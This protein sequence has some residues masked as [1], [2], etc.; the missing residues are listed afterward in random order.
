MAK[1]RRLPEPIALNDGRVLETLAD[2]RDLMI[3]LP[4][5]RYDRPHWEH[6][7]ELLTAAE[8]GNLARAVQFSDR[9]KDAL[10]AEGLI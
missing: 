7:A 5:R 3:M 1:S 8:R 10:K 2:A 9:L 4:N 6:V